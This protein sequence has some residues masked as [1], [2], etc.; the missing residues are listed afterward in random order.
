MIVWPARGLSGALAPREAGRSW[1][2]HAFTRGFVGSVLTM[3]ADCGLQHTRRLLATRR[4]RRPA[5]RPSP[6]ECSLSSGAS[7]RAPIA[8]YQAA[9]PSRV[10]RRRVRRSGSDA[11]VRCAVAQCAGPLRGVRRRPEFDQPDP[12][13]P[14]AG[15]ITMRNVAIRCCIWISAEAP[16]RQVA[17][18]AAHLPRHGRHIGEQPNMLR[19]RFVTRHHLRNVAVETVDVA[20]GPGSR[21][22][23]AASA[24]RIWPCSSAAMPKPSPVTCS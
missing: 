19:N 7:R 13:V 17:P 15:A 18:S 16:P 1:T 21:T 22:V 11:Y 2:G 14:N 10:S 23:R 9:P 12:P 5:P 24:T 8:P 20:L 6:N 3:Y 4:G